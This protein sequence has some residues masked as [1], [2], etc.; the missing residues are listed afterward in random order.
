MAEAA[1]ELVVFDL[2]G[3]LLNADSEISGFTQETLAALRARGIPYTVA[4]GRARHGAADLLEGLGFDLPQAF[5][6]GVLLWHPLEAL[7]SHH[8]HLRLDEIRSVLEA[9]RA[10][11]LSPFLA[12][13]EPGNVHRI[14]HAPELNETEQALARAFRERD[15]VDL[16]DLATLPADAEITSISALGPREAVERLAAAVAPFPEL[17]AYAGDAFEGPGLGWIDIHHGAGTK[18]TAV[19]ALK[20][21]LNVER[22]VVFGDGS[23]DLPMFAVADEAYAPSNARP[24]VLQAAT[25]VI[26]HHDEDGIAAFL[27]ERFNL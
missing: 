18:G 1:S 7:Y 11:G 25:A 19:E 26:G 2:D 10:E 14:Y 17:V 5:K 16:A 20:T 4:T 27:Q 6:N 23:N 13:L 22:L 12:T 24:E 15:Q 21:M 3:T 9:S 8:H